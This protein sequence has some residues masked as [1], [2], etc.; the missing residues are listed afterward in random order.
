[1]LENDLSMSLLKFK[2][3]E[4]VFHILDEYIYNIYNIQLQ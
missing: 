4:N 3:I 1:M 2:H